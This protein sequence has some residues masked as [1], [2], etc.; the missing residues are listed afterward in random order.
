MSAMNATLEI[1][2]RTAIVCL[3]LVQPN[4]MAK[5]AAQ[6]AAAEFAAAVSVQQDKSAQA[7]ASVYRAEPEAAHLLISIS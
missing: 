7:T 4:V 2:A 6:T 5:F 1:H 3:L